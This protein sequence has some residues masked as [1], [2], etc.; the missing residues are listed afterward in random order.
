MSV[1]YAFP[2]AWT[3]FQVKVD[4]NVVYRNPAPSREFDSDV[5][6]DSVL[7]DAA[8]AESGHQKVE[9]IAVRYGVVSHPGR[10]FTK[11]WFRGN[12]ADAAYAARF[13]K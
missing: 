2:Y 7:C 9:G 5:F 11:V 10:E 8:V 3:W 6:D 1:R 12:W 13:S 4:G